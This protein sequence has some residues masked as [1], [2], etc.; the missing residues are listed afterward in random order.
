M[1]EK[2]KKQVALLLDV[3]PEVA[4]EESFALH[5]GTAINLFVREMPRLSV[6]IDLTYV[7]VADRDKSF[8][9]II[10]ALS[11]I[12][13]R[14]EK[15][16]KGAKVQLQKR[17]LKLFVDLKGVQIKL[18]VNQINRGCIEEPVEQILCEK[19]QEMFD[20]FVSVKVVP[21]SQLFGG[22]IIAALDR[23]HPRDLFDVKFLLQDGD[24]PTGMA[25][26]LVFCLL[27]S[28]R[29]IRELLDPHLID[30]RQVLEYQFE[31]MTSESFTYDEFERTR[32][33][34]I[35]GVNALLSPRDKDFILSFKRLEPDWNIYDF[36]RFPAIRWK[37]E[38]LRRFKQDRNSGYQG[39]L[40]R[41]E[42]LFNSLPL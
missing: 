23:Q 26:G 28:N 25:K 35:R 31:G 33:N 7:E 41:L 30:Q 12:E 15:V 37:L 13:K 27:S 39:A 34:L 21:D 19:A 3:L 5:G 11:A 38:N 22:K 40:D 16:V 14:L 20:A 8:E 29:P 6:D 18:E 32:K 1:K 17:Q 24:L 2:Y 42:A 10:A 36:E 9:V 4:R